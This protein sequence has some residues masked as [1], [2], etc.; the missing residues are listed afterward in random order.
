MR[1]MNRT[2]RRKGMAMRMRNKV[3]KMGKGT[4][5]TTVVSKTGISI[6]EEP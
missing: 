3:S 4:I 5:L 2:R 1:T 6:H